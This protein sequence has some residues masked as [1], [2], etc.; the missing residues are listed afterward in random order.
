MD[1]R[2]ILFLIIWGVG[3]AAIAVWGSVKKRLPS[4]KQRIKTGR[5]VALAKQLQAVE[6]WIDNNPQGFKI[7][8]S[9]KPALANIDQL[10]DLFDDK[11]E[12][13]DLTAE[14]YKDF[15]YTVKYS[16]IM[17]YAMAR[18]NGMK[19]KEY[20]SGWSDIKALDNLSDSQVAAKVKST[21][22]SVGVL[23]NKYLA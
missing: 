17:R 14:M 13:N 4:E 11:D 22:D 23:S 18:S 15:I 2:L 3:M 20:G 8:K 10:T 9:Y 19:I 12:E 16:L 5:L 6:D 1:S 21:I 7:Q